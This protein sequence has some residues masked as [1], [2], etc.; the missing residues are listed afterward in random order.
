MKEIKVQPIG[1]ARQG[2]IVVDKKWSKGLSGIEGFSHLLVFFWLDKTHKPDLLIRPKSREKFPKIGFL[3]TRTPHRPNPIG[4]TVVK[5][6]RR[7][8]PKLW[9]RGLDAWDGTLI[10]DLKPY[11]KREAVGKYRM[12][13]WVKK[14]DQLEKDPLRKYAT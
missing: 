14:L 10:L 2:T 12:P 9:V 4:F 8:G 6:I 3:A 1:F 13:G 5:L 7:K 11:T